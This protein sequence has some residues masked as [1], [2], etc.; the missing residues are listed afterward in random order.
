MAETYSL[1][2]GEGIVLAQMKNKIPGYFASAGI[3]SGIGVKFG[4]IR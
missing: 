2:Q 3:L 4:S 1:S